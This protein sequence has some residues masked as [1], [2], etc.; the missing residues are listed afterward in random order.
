M[1]AAKKKDNAANFFFLSL[2][3]NNTEISI[4]LGELNSQMHAMPENFSLIICP[5]ANTIYPKN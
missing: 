1:A 3:Q 5:F 4:S 2:K